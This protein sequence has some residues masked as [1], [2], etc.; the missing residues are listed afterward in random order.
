MQEL[1]NNG[2]HDIH[3]DLSEESPGAVIPA[4]VRAG[5]GYFNGSCPS[6]FC[7]IT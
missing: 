7:L 2:L 6:T 5:A 3:V 1:D 4:Y